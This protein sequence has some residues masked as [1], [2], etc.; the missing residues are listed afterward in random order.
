[1]MKKMVLILLM[2]AAVLSATAQDPLAD[3]PWL[4]SRDTNHIR[5]KRAY[6]TDN[7][8]GERQLLFTVQYD[9]HGFY[10]DSTHHNVYDSQGRLTMQEVYTWVSSTANPIP[11]RKTK[12]RWSIEYAY[13]G[14][15][16]HIRHEFNGYGQS[17]VEDY[18]L[19][20]RK[21]HPRFGLTDCIFIYNGNNTSDTL[22]FHREYDSAG[23]LLREWCSEGL[24]EYGDFRYS[25][26]AS[27]RLATRVNIYYESWDSLSY[28]YDPH[29]VLTSATGKAYDLD[30]EADVTITFRPDGTRLEGREH[31]IV[32]SDPSY[33]EDNY[34][35]Y[36]EHG[37][38][39]YRKAVHGIEEYE[40][41]YWE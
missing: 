20:S 23:H 30:M 12:E 16:Q 9:R 11:H 38:E 24:E 34:I 21:V 18:C 5:T 22:G 10:A 25:Y 19:H 36:D 32:Y 35:R 7:R 41:E 33:S 26:D 13:D 37:L 2:M 15:V 27:G 14:A 3:L 31:W 40:I 8:T 4:P 39:V 29:G 6:Y 1:M 28:H 17:D